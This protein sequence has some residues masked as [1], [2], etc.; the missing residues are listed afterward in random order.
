MRRVFMSLPLLS[1]PNHHSLQQTE[2]R[3][4]RKMKIKSDWIHVSLQQCSLS[5]CLQENVSVSIVCLLCQERQR[6][7]E[8]LAFLVR[9]TDNSHLHFEVGPDRASGQPRFWARFPS[10]WSGCRL[11]HGVLRGSVG[12]EV[13]LERKLL[14]TQLEDQEDTSTYGLR[15]GWSTDN[16]S[17]LLGKDVIL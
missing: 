4:R 8:S 10:L 15:V 3:R 12:F 7:F 13:R 16:A 9:F 11:T 1:E 2:R 17:L 14:A 5:F 6:R